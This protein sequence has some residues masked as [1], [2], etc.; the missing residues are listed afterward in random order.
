MVVPTLN[1]S[2]SRELANLLSLFYQ[3]DNDSYQER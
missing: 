1:F 2:T 3:R